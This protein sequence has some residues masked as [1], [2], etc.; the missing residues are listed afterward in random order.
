MPRRPSDDDSPLPTDL[1]A[2]NTVKE[3]VSYIETEHSRAGLKKL[4]EMSKD[5]IIFLLK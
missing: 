3:L 1:E 5:D 2:L 4:S